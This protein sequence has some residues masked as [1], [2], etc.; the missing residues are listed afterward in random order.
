MKVKYHDYIGLGKLP[1]EE[2]KSLIYD[3]T[4]QKIYI[5][6][7]IT[8]L[9]TGKLLVPM[10]SMATF[11]YIMVRKVTLDGYMPLILSLVLSYVLGFLVQWYVMD[12][13]LELSEIDITS[14]EMLD[15]LEAQMIN[16]KKLNH[17][18][19]FLLGFTLFFS[20]SYIFSKSLVDLIG[21]FCIFFCV[22]LFYFSGIHKRYKVL[23]DLLNLYKCQ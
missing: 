20:I 5:G 19:Y 10:G 8:K 16:V 2:N 11:L 18:I 12:V 13:Q 1:N 9:P 21:S 17:S 6:V 22:P 23:K 3:P 15:F 7:Q 14:Q 4:S